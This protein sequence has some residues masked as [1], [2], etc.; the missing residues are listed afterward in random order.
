MISAR[1]ELV[2]DATHFFNY[3]SGATNLPQLNALS[4][5]PDLM[6][7]DFLA[8]IDNEIEHQE[9]FG[10]GRIIAKMNALTDKSI[11]LKLYQASQAGVKIDL[12]VRGICCLK[13]GIPGVSEQIRVHSIVGRF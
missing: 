1:E 10:T 13:P 9:Q 8:L 5:A 3:L 2:R 12:I 11:I 6:L 7:N 4:V